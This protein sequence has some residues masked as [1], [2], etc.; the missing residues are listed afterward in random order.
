MEVRGYISDN[1]ITARHSHGG[2][3]MKIPM[4][5]VGTMLLLLPASVVAQTTTQAD[6]DQIAGILKPL[7][8]KAVPNVLHEKKDNWDHQAMV[9]VGLKWRGIRAEV[10]KSPRNH[11]DW[12]KL[13]ITAQDIDRTLDLRISNLKNI[14]ADRQSFRTFLTFQMGVQYEHQTWQNGVRVW[15]GYVR[16]RAQV[17]CEMNCESTIKADFSNE[18]LPDFTVRIRVTDARVGYDKLVLENIN[19]IGGSA[20]KVTGDA[21]HKAMKQWQPSIERDLLATAANAIVK[22]ADTREMR[23]SL[24]TLLKV[25]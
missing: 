16:A 24:S 7:V 17:K 11:G 4:V 15:N 1:E 18:L 23:L 19:G 21:A 12:S 3:A 5:T 2:I 14:D 25:K 8:V 20:A 13:L 9:P 10:Q 22:T 6:L